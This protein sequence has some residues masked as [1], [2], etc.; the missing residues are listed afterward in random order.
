MEDLYKLKTQFPV[1]RNSVFSVFDI[2]GTSINRVSDF[3]V[4]NIQNI[5][6]GDCAL[7]GL[8]Y[9]STDG[10]IHI[11]EHWYVGS[12]EPVFHEVTINCCSWKVS[13]PVFFP[14]RIQESD[15]W[16]SIKRLR[17]SESM[18]SI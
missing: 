11:H 9:G 7:F 17:A 1:K 14:G 4:F 6:I 2:E 13:T 18:L 5:G 10:V 15:F 8:Q 3:S 16:R 12:G